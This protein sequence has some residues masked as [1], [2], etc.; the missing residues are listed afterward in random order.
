MYSSID[1][2]AALFGGPGRTA[3]LR[4]LAEQSAPLTGRQIGELTGLSPA[5]ASRALEHLASVG[6]IARRRVGRAVLHELVRDNLVVETIVLPVFG[7]EQELMTHLVDD[8]ADTFGPGA[9]NVTLFGSLGTENG[10][11]G[12]DIDVLVVTSNDDAAARASAL[13]DDVG[14]DFF[15]RFGMPLSV[16][17]T[18][19]HALPQSPGGFL[20]AARDEGV[21]V[22]GR[23]LRE[24]M[25][26]GT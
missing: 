26:S 6:V 21:L 20:A 1:I 17:V 11:P 10:T 8:L 19:L 18:P 23:P 2:I 15:V 12:S 25:G 13:A 24:L 22:S 9:E 4:L 5:G 7:A 14:H 3:I 16:I